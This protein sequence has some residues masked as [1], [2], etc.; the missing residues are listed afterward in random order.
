MP[1]KKIV[2]LV[3]V[4]LVVVACGLLG[5]LVYQFPPIHDRL[6]WRLDNLRTRIRYSLNPPEL[7]V[8]VPQEQTSLEITEAY[9][10]P[11]PTFT[12]D[13]G[14]TLTPTISPTPQGPTVTPTVTPSP[15]LSP[16]SIP[17]AVLLNGITH[18]Y[19]Q[20]NNC[21]PATL[22]M[23]LTFWGWL[24]DQ[25]DTRAFLRPNFA[26]FDDK[27]VSPY[28]MATYVESQTQLSAVV[29]VGGDIDILKHLIAAGF[30]VIIEKGFQPP[31]EDWMGHYALITGYDDTRNRFITQD[32]YIMPDFP[33][34]YGDLSGQWWRDFNNVYLVIYP[35]DRRSDLFAVL[36]PQIDPV[37]NYGSAAQNAR[38]EI[39]NLTGRDQFFAWYNLG[40]N[41][42]GITDYVGAAYAY[43]QAF[44]LYADLPEDERPWR[45]LWYQV[46]PYEAYF[47]SRRYQD[48]ITL[49]N[50]TLSFLGAP[51]LEESLYWRGLSKE[52]LGDLEGAIADLVKAAE[53]NPTSTDVLVQLQRLGVAF[54][55]VLNGK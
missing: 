18:E 30:P 45:L 15:T 36:G 14:P 34:P 51:V 11:E 35:L 47:H 32:S 8:F 54:P 39:E 43:D 26:T 25:R 22:S 17:E 52:A 53:I 5:A 48:V 42:L 24:G 4:V 37:G 3:L 46:G 33:V 12:P 31:K 40:T 19:Q 44:E 6:S 10:D 27:N 21:G 13:D 7:A 55:L 38:Q 20:M 49:A 16:T 2:I 9:Q 50:Q 1:Q 41:L 23:A 28:E 29:R